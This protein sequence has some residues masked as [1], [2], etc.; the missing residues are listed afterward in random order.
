MG[1]RCG[2]YGSH[3]TEEVLLELA[4]RPVA[5]GS[6]HKVL[7]SERAETKLDLV[8]YYLAVEEPLLRAV[9]GRPALMQRFPHGAE[10]SSFFQKR[11]PD[12]APPWLHTAIV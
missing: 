4:G 6:P 9:R 1:S 3:V 5:V 8:R 7:F 2:S 12:T 10:G 11:V